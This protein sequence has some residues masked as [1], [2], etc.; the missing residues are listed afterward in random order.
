M[1]D[2]VHLSLRCRDRNSRPQTAEDPQEAMIPIGIT[3][4]RHIDLFRLAG[5][6][7]KPWRHYADD[8]VRQLVNP[9]RLAQNV[10]A[11]CKMPLPEKIAQEHNPGRAGFLF[12][13]AKGPAERW[14][15]AQSLEKSR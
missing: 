13:T 9:N 1:R 2:D 6:N 5:R 10:G 3:N 4:H 15:H 8:C 7:F 14:Q 12:I 11:L